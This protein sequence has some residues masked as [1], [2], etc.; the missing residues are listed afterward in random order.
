MQKRTWFVASLVC[1]VGLRGAGCATQTAPSY[2]AAGSVTDG[3]FLTAPLWNDGQAE[4]AFYEVERTHRQE[5]QD[6]P[7]RFLAGTYLVK[8]AFDRAAMSKAG[9]DAPQSL[10]AFKYALF[11][12]FESGSYQYKHNYVI[13]A[14]QADLTPLKASFTS[15][16]WCSNVYSELAF[17]ARGTVDALMR[18]DDYG[19]RTGTFAYRPQAY[20]IHLLPLLVRSLD[21]SGTQ[22][23]TFF[24]VEDDG[25]YVRVQAHRDGLVSIELPF[26]GTKAERIVLTYDVPVRSLISRETDSV[27]TYWRGTG[28]ARQLLRIEGAS[29]RYRMSLVEELRTAYWRE[30]LWPRLA[31]VSQR[32]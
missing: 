28:P 19:N 1:L 23:L 16:D 13:N 14:A 10:S 2:D 20:P 22:D 8:H 7:Q 6:V 17:H 32:P 24:V 27:E 18:S 31:R 3:A 30:D 25:A 4:V 12:E 26:G 11:Y 5:G 29:G 9:P 21:F 15:F